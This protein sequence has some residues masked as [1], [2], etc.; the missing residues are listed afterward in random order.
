[1]DSSWIVFVRWGDMCLQ[2]GF[3]AGILWALTVLPSGW[4]GNHETHC[5]CF[6]LFSG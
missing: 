6:S 3:G 2:R 4:R 1:M 5:V